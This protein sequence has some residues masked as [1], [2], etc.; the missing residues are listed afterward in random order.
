VSVEVIAIAFTGLI[1]MA[2]YLVQARS[3]QKASEAQADIER[4]A[5]ERGEV[6]VKAR[7]QLERVQL[8]IAELMQPTLGLL[9]QLYLAYNRAVYDC[10]LE[11]YVATFAVNF[12]SPPTQPHVA[13]FNIGLPEMM[14]REA[15]SPFNCTLPPAD[16][17]RLA[18]DP[19]KQ[20]L[21]ENLVMHTMLP[22]LREL[23]PILCTKVRRIN[24]ASL[25]FRPTHL[26]ISRTEDV[27]RAWI[28]RPV[29][30]P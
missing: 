27:R 6:E 14:K 8:Q 9:G 3:A 20:A 17:A 21:W 18:T 28:C 13:A 15:A 19:T 16:L 1:S 26:H 10:G 25:R 11:E 23:G 22:P 12:V 24:L 5:R 7:Q 2:G 29:A 4:E 30:T